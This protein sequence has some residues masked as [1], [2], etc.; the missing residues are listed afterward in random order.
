MCR[1]CRIVAPDHA[2]FRPRLRHDSVTTAFCRAFGS[3]LKARS[4]QQGFAPQS[5]LR[6]RQ[7][8]RSQLKRSLS[9]APAVHSDPLTGNIAAAVT[10]KECNGVG[11][12]LRLA[13]KTER[14][15]TIQSTHV[16]HA[17]GKIDETPPHIGVDEAWSDDV[18][19]NSV[20]PLFL[21]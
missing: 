7:D 15:A 11:D 2:G 20:L 3:R 21:R 17:S 1:Q 12:I 6:Y 4:P 14:A 5:A 9:E 8:R 18:H 13:H 19:T 10:H 16:G